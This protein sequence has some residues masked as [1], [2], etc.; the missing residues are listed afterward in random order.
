MRHDTVTRA[1]V[2][3]DERYYCTGALFVDPSVTRITSSAN[4]FVI[5][6]CI[7]CTLLVKVYEEDKDQ[8]DVDSI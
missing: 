2:C 6:T 4:V 7:L 1:V 8:S 5:W 3:F